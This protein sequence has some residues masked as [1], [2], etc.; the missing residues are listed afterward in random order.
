[1]E[2]D[3][4]AV[5]ERSDVDV[6][7][8]CVPG[9]LHAEIAIAAS[10]AGRIGDI[11][12]IRARYLRDWLIDPDFPLVWRL[13]KEQ[14]G[15]GALGDLGAHIIDLAQYI[16]GQS[17]T[18]VS[19]QTETFVTSR[20]LPA[21]SSG[22]GATASELRGEVTVDDAAIILARTDGAHSPHSGPPDTRPDGRTRCASKSTVPRGSLA[23][24]F[25]RLNELEFADATPPDV[26]A[27]FR[28]ILVSEPGHPYVGAWWPA[29]HGLGYEHTFVHQAK[30]CVDDIMHDRTSTPSFDD[31]LGVQRVLDS[32]ERSAASDSSWM[33]VDR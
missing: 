11:R 33:R 20:P 1:V 8:N 26:E 24:D 28:R 16:S 17:I 29:G 27:G 18:G 2:T 12:H 5:L 21:T 4:R 13:I 31:G 15:S 6:V 19:A 30:D 32:V 9:H 23:F 10:E 7:D 22:L 14:A 25:E 3:W